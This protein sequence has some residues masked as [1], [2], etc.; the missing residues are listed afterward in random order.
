[1]IKILELCHGTLEKM[2][3]EGMIEGLMEA[4]TKIERTFFL[5]ETGGETPTD[6]ILKKNNLST[7]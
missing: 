4:M 2:M 6:Y 5:I 7:A 1:V 3:E